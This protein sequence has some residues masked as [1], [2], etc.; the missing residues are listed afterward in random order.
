MFYSLPPVGS[1][2]FLREILSTAGSVLFGSKAEPAFAE[3]LK[4]YFETGHCFLL[5]SGRAALTLVLQ[6]LKE[7]DV[8]G[9]VIIPSYTCFS[10][11][12][13]VVRAGLKV[14]ICDIR[15]KTLDFDYE[16]LE[17][18]ITDKTLAIIPC[19]LY[20]L[21]SD[22][23]RVKDLAKSKKV[24]VIEDAAQAMG[25]KLNGRHAGTIGD[26]GLFS[27]GRGKSVTTQGGGVILTN[28]GGLAKRIL[29]RVEA[30]PVSSKPGMLALAQALSHAMFIHPRLYWFPESIPNFNLGGTVYD[31]QFTLDRYSAIQANQGLRVLSRLQTENTER[32]RKAAHYRRHLKGADGLVIPRPLNGSEPIYIRFP[33]FLKSREEKEKALQDL[34]TKGLGVHYSYPASIGDIS[35]LQA[36]FGGH[37]HCERGRIA[38]AKILTLPT[39]YLVE[40]RHMC[41]IEQYLNS[42]P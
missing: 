10:V 25:A 36:Y 15:L 42:R 18:C 39:H 30:Y 13:A 38:A 11:P 34:R 12:A 7:G 1:K 29:S 21:L 37:V 26:V 5:N 22:V 40:D 23:G 33:I 17:S 27:L 31:P 3:A 2:V 24:W 28:D 19:H 9:E 35:D 16:Q 4:K 41:A 6:A 32:L 20:G 14:S 8:R